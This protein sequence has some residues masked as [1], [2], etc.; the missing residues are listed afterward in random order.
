VILYNLFTQCNCFYVTNT[1]KIQFNRIY[2]TSNYNIESYNIETIQK[3]NNF[4]VKENMNEFINE[5]NN[6]KLSNIFISKDYSKLVGV[7]LTTSDS[8][9]DNFYLTQSNSIEI[10]AILNKAYEHNIPANFIDFNPSSATFDSIKQVLDIIGGIA[11][12][13][14]PIFFIIL[15]FSGLRQTSSFGSPGMS[16]G[17]MNMINKNMNR[18]DIFVTPNVS[19]SSW[20]G[21]PEVLE[22]CKEVV[23]Y[24]D[25]KE[26]FK[27]T[28]A[29]MPKGILLEGP[30]GTGKTLIAKGIATETNSSFISVSGAEF[31]ELFVGMGAARVR[32]L[33]RNARENSPCIIFIDEIDAIGKQRGNNGGFAAND[34]REQTLNQIL[35][36]MDG[37]SN[38]EGI[39][40]LAATN[41]RDILDKALLRPGRFDRIIKVPL[42]DKYSRGKILDYYCG[43][44]QMEPNT[45]IQSLAE[46]TD[47]FSGAELKNLINE[48]AILTARQ[49]KTIIGEK[50][51]FNAFE[52]LI[53]GLIRNNNNASE[54]TKLRVAIH[55]SGHAILALRYPEYF[56]LQKVSI[57]AT[58]GGAGGYTIF[59]ENPEIKEGGLY[60]RDVLKKRLI[61]TLG[62][63]AAEN[64]YYGND[65]VSVGATQD[66]KQAN[67]LAQKMISN[68]GMGNKLEVFYNENMDDTGG[69][70]TNNKYSEQTKY[71]LDKE[72]LELVIE[73]YNESKR[74]LSENQDLLATMTE[75][76][77]KN[78]V[79]TK[80]D[81]PY[82]MF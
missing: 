16:G 18:D 74:I 15:F 37:F 30:P 42:P 78:D 7:K 51:L 59:T 39:L 35:F 65:F 17:P 64:V 54:N 34:E 41:R 53:V 14:I 1:R 81:I 9:I 11:S 50:E 71:K 48:A 56:N 12:Y 3:Y 62:G 32:D 45:D 25:N 29:E 76:L 58:Y 36:E 31:V 5:I 70:F 66:L 4:F 46:I 77:L 63:K 19:L 67:Q 69:L 21:S 43:L 2:T 23:S 10:P 27:Q 72:S 22:E 57:Q 33:F 6:N 49:N 24:L 28:G 55:E 61:V 80:K 75:L 20:A 73:A 68:F 13:A 52:K 47:G 79:L 40:I 60:T 8:I 26:L 44:K 38:N 82:Y